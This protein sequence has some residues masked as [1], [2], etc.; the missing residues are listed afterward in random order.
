MTSLIPKHSVPL[1]SSINQKCGRYFCN[2]CLKGSYQINVDSLTKP[3]ELSVN[4][5][6]V[7]QAST[8]NNSESE[9]E[10]SKDKSKSKNILKDWCCPWCLN[11]C[12]CSRCLREEQILKLVAT[13]FYYEGDLQDLLIN[14]LSYHPIL[15]ALRNQIVLSN[16]EIKDFSFQ[17]RQCKNSKGAISVNGIESS[18]ITEGVNKKHVRLSKK[19]KFESIK[20]GKNNKSCKLIKSKSADKI[21]IVNLEYKVQQ[22]DELIESCK[23]EKEEYR[24][25]QKILSEKI[26]SKPFSKQI[27]DNRV[28][29]SYFEKK[30][31]GRP[32]KGRSKSINSIALDLNSTEE[33][34]SKIIKTKSIGKREK[35]KS[36]LK[37]GCKKYKKVVEDGQ[38]IIKSL[39]TI[40]LLRRKRRSRKQ[41][42]NN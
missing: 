19:G 5:Q 34:S 7:S 36:K 6:G 15:K 25:I 8:C 30:S 38:R 42:G 21:D 26:I 4:S 9:K 28:N 11:D 29:S 17:E 23:I 35:S 22:L 18:E 33:N 1:L 31:V 3:V 39:G 24:K 10:K 27:N 20:N 12:F 40:N 37:F 13:F 41:N 32:R 16:L 14:I 2:Y